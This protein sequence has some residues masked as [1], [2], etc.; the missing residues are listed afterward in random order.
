MQ[1]GARRRDVTFSRTF[2][3]G[4]LEKRR[5]RAYSGT[6]HTTLFHFC[7]LVFLCLGML[8][9]KCPQIGTIVNFLDESKRCLTSVKSVP[10]GHFRYIKILT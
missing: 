9:T 5:G 6:Y 1:S 8:E 4:H 7:L 2:V 10:I 3:G